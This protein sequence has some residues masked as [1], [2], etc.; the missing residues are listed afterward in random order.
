MKRV[1][2]LFFGLCLLLLAVSVTAQTVKWQEIY[3]VK[4]KDTIYG[5]AKRYNITIDDLMKA[6]PIMQV[7]D[8][9]LKKGAQLLIPYPSAKVVTPA[10]APTE[11]K[12]AATTV[13]KA[14]TGTVRVGVMLPLH[15]ADGD[16]QRMLEYYRGVLMACDSLKAQG[17]NT[18]IH[19]WNVPIDANVQQTLSDA[20][21]KDCDVIFGP[22]YTKQV[23][24]VGEFCRKNDIRL[25][26]PFSISGN[27]VESND[28]IFQVYQ[29]PQQQTDA[30]IRAYIDRF[31]GY[32]TVIVD[33]ND[34]TSRKGAFTFA[35]R[36]QLNSQGTGYSITNIKSSEAVFAKA[37][38]TTKP[39]VVVLNTGRSPEL[40]VTLAKLNGM[41]ALNPNLKV[42]LFGYT[43]WLMYTKVYLDYYYRYDTY[44]PTTFYYNALAGKTIGLEHAYRRWFKSD[45]RQALPRFAITGYDQ[46]QYF[47]RGIH[48]Y[49]RQFAGSAQ[50]STYTPLQTPLKFRRIQ[51]GG[52]QNSAFMLIHYKPNRTLDAISY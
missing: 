40:N 10:K 31:R 52:L 12:P 7:P 3:H 4:K 9:T 24:A 5:I 25:V 45:M 30:A 36:K 22:L 26:I 46:A 8:Y 6:N 2:K 27:D 39:N 51:G 29:T 48:K 33:C 44:I 42:S 14:V 43:E 11:S 49:G 1:I 15:N 21:A 23:K 50:Q 20:N 35:L 13:K 47:I 19:A 28:H 32:H 34:T 38:S 16:G 37:F 18:T 17:I 41:K